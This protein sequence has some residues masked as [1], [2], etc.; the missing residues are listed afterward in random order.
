M[1]IVW[2][3][4]SSRK[5]LQQLD[6]RVQDLLKRRGDVDEAVRKTPAR[7]ELRPGHPGSGDASR[8]ELAASLASQEKFMTVAAPRRFR[9]G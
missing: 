1:S 9:L 5:Q 4:P 8:D 7:L 3:K 2:T 6:G